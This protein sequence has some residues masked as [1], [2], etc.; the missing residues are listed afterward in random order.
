M[1]AEESDPLKWKKATSNR[2]LN[3]NDSMKFDDDD[4]THI[5]ECAGQLEYSRPDDSPFPGKNLDEGRVRD[6]QYCL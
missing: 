5:R 3:N 1:D 2:Y 6:Q 4:K